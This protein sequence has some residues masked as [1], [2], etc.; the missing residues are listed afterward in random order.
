MIAESV[1]FLRRRRASA[2][3]TTP[4]TSST[5]Y[6]DDPAYALRCLRAAAEAGRR[7]RH[8]LRHQRLLAAGQVAEATAQRGRRARRDGAGRHPHPRRRRLR[9]G[10][11]AGGGRAR[12]RAWC[13][14]R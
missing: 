5:A 6:R 13:R 12:A 8:A 2:S 4:S 10:Q 9:R 3:S 11:L 1:A 14:A 7:E